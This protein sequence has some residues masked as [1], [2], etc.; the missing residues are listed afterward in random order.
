[1]DT[2]NG[3]SIDIQRLTE[4]FERLAKTEW[5]KQPVLG[6]RSSETRVLLCIKNLSMEENVAITVSEISKRM[7]ITSPTVTQLIKHLNENGY[8][9]RAVDL[10]DK[11]SVDI[12]L[13]EKGEK[14]AQKASDYLNTLFS[15]L[16]KKLG[17][18]QCSQLIFLLDQVC[19]YLNETHV[20]ID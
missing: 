3:S 13:T 12:T 15:G 9:E 8:V 1:M 10:K 16:I 19:D 7:Q 5:R 14:I 20:E 6:V 11:R 2:L 18:E 4:T 17:D